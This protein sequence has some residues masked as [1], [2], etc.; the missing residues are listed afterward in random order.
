[1]IGEKKKC[2]HHQVCID[3]HAH[4]IPVVHTVT[5]RGLLQIPYLFVINVP[6]KNTY[7][8]QRVKTTQKR[9]FGIRFERANVRN[10]TENGKRSDHPLSVDVDQSMHGNPITF[11]KDGLIQAVG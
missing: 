6:G 4:H 3:H 11:A 8:V 9:H 5:K 1:M 10:P 7:C 2:H